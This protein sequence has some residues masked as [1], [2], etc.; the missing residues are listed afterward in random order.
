MKLRVIALGHEHVA[1]DRRSA[2]TLGEMLHTLCSA[3]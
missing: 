2:V 1:K 3:C